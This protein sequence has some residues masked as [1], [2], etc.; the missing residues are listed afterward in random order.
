MWGGT[1]TDKAI[2]SVAEKLRKLQYLC[3]GSSFLTDNA[4]DIIR[5]EQALLSS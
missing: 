1:I 4:I 3:L 2:F 5:Y